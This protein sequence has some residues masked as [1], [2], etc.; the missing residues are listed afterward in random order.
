MCMHA[1][2]LLPFFIRNSK[3]SVNVFFES[4]KYLKFYEHPDFGTVQ[5]LGH[6]YDAAGVYTGT[7]TNNA[8]IPS[9]YFSQ[10]CNDGNTYD[11]EYV[12]VKFPFHIQFS[13]IYL[14]GIVE[15]DNYDFFPKDLVILALKHNDTYDC[16]GRYT[17][18]NIS[19]VDHN[20]VT[21]VK[22]KGFKI[23]FL[24]GSPDNNNRGSIIYDTLKCY[25]NIYSVQ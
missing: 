4:C 20:M 14:G 9:A 11:G 21:S 6:S 3:L 7:T 25:G 13:N 2:I 15:G 12:E 5:Y 22:Y 23:I 18:S 8:S 1:A 19:F 10:L 24:M 16:I 17:Y